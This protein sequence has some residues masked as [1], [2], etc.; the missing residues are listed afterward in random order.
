MLRCFSMRID[1]ALSRLYNQFHDKPNLRGVLEIICKGYD[2]LDAAITYLTL[3]VYTA[4]GVWLDLIGAIAGQGRRVEV[5]ITVEYFG[6]AETTGGRGFGQARFRTQSD[7]ITSTD[8][9]ADPEYRKVILARVAKNYGNIS[10]PGITQAL[11]V[12]LDTSNIYVRSAGN[13]KISVSIGKLLTDT[14][15]A[16]VTSLDIIPV[17]EG[18]GVEYRSTYDPEGTFGFADSPLGFKGFGQGSFATVF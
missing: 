11:Q 18:I 16:L 13:A 4:E 10:K 15:K 1:D 12:I 2:D 8:I 5:P 9:L 14:E 17:G 7:S 3:N 6:F